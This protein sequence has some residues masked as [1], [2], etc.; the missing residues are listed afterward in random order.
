MIRYAF[1]ISLKKAYF[2]LG[3][4]FQGNFMFNKVLKTIF[5]LLICAVMGRYAYYHFSGSTAEV[6]TI[7]KEVAIKIDDAFTQ[8]DHLQKLMQWSTFIDEKEYP[9]KVFYTPYQGRYAA[10]TLSSQD[11][12]KTIELSIKKRKHNQYL[13]Y[14]ILDNENTQPFLLDVFFTPQKSGNTLL[15]YQMT[16]PSRKSLFTDELIDN[17]QD[18][19]TKVNESMVRL[20]AHIEKKNRREDLLVRL[21][22]DSIETEKINAMSYLGISSSSKNTTQDWLQ[23]LE[24]NH[25]KIKSF[26]TYDLGINEHDVGYMTLFYAPESLMREVQYFL[27]VPLM[28]QPPI[29]DARFTSQNKAESY[30]LIRYYKG[31]WEGRGKAQKQLLDKAK[32]EKKTVRYFA[33]VFLEKP[34][35]DHPILVK[36][37]LAYE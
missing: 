26:T 22:F 25:T 12:K 16:L 33:M 30:A 18:F 32:K 2:C 7:E 11:K 1:F 4:Y 29:S 35:K 14:Q 28:Q 17:E 21:Q 8:F 6:I 31:S 24:Q 9:S 20:K 34:R 15:R 3:N 27:G 37:I 10:A 13:Q 36:M 19:H 23:S 5:I